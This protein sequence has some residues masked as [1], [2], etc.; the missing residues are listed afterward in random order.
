MRIAAGSAVIAAV[1]GESLI[2]RDGPRRRVLLR[3]PTLDLPRAFGAAIVIVVVSVVVFALAGRSSVPCTPAGAD[4][5]RRTPAPEPPDQHI[6]TGGRTH[7]Q[8]TLVPR[9]IRSAA[10]RRRSCR[11]SRCSPRAATTTMT[12]PPAPRRA[13][14]RAR[15]RPARRR[16]R[17][18]RRH[19]GRRIA[20]HRAHAFS[21]VP[22][23]EWAAWYLAD[24]NGYFAGAGRRRPS[25]S[26][27]VRT[28]RPS[29]RSWPP[30]TPTS[31]VAGDELS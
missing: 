31:G 5:T 16:R 28:R 1:V 30:A 6:T 17:H 18:D 23:I 21:W 12:T 4:T 7:A 13:P 29:S 11:P 26:T 15:R 22:D 8:P 24:A 3:L 19:R 20:R 27:A 2:G 14:R 9:P 25:S 10:R